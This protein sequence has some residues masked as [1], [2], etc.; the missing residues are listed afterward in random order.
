[1]LQDPAGAIASMPPDLRPGG[2]GFLGGGAPFGP[3]AGDFVGMVRSLRD[4][5][6]AVDAE[7]R[8]ADTSPQ[9]RVALAGALRSRLD[10]LVVAAPGEVHDE[11][12]SVHAAVVDALGNALQQG[13]RSSEELDVARARV[14]AALRQGGVGAAWSSVVDYLGEHYVVLGAAPHEPA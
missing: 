5:A 14:E 9:R 1:M 4:R 2:L 6:P 10:A 12:A 13:V 3:D 11:V 7:L 8:R